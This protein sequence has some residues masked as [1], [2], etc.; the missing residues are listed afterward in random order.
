MKLI[1]AAL[2]GVG[3]AI[4]AVWTAPLVLF[5]AF[6]IAWG[7]EAAQFL[8]SQG[9]ALAIL[10]WLQT[11][12]EF[13]V[14][15]TLAWQAGHGTEADVHLVTA[16]FTGSIRLIMGFGMPI[17]YFIFSRFWTKQRHAQP[18]VLDRFHSIEVISLFPPVIYFVYIVHKGTLDL[19][20]AIVMLGFY[21]LYLG[22]LMKMPAEEEGEEDISELP[23][24]SRWILR[25][26]RLGR[27]F[28]CIFVFVLG[29]A[30][31]FFTVHEFIESLKS[32]AISVGVPA[33][34][35]IQWVAPF[36]SEM[37]E[38]VS[39]F[40]WAAKPN[41]AAMA[42][43]NF[44][45]SNVNQLTV[46]VAMV[47]IVFAAA[48]WMA[49]PMG[50][51]VND[52]ARTRI[53]PFV[54][55]E[56]GPKIID[57]RR[58]AWMLYEH[59][60]VGLVMSKV[61]QHG[62]RLTPAAADYLRA[63]LREEYRTAAERRHVKGLPTIVFNDE[64]KSEV[65]LTVAQTLLCLVVLLNMRFEWQEAV[66]MF[67]LFMGQFLSPVWAPFIGVTNDG[68]RAW[69]TLAYLA[70]VGIEVILCLTRL[71]KW[72]FPMLARPSLTIFR[73]RT[74]GPPAKS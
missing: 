55:A 63:Q 30:I 5:S 18:I 25:R 45:S 33:F 8:M 69:C 50:Q 47:P 68:V 52:V 28:G 66:G 57:V 22:L 27:I 2:S 39:A 21:A 49:P 1:V 67:A 59:R 41:R 10:A 7:A 15:A 71:R 51:L 61:E 56:S 40:A 16:N 72:Q 43:M 42:L 62:E 48:V 9:L 11:L 54:T 53:D 31:L 4:H 26:G 3:K 64:Q 17:V 29:G 74:S 65:M 19:V 14:E 35:F 58:A 37:P 70:W 44:L 34:F 38:K 12:P 32:L 46:L 73:R 13:A 23:L 36:L 6:L 20:D 24:V 60:S